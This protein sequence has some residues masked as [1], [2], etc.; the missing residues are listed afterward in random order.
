MKLLNSVYDTD[1]SIYESFSTAIKNDKYTSWSWAVSSFDD[2]WLINECFLPNP[3]KFKHLYLA[4]SWNN[5]PIKNIQSIKDQLKDYPSVKFIDAKRVF[6]PKVY[7]FYN[8]DHTLWEAFVGSFNLIFV[9]G[10]EYATIESV[11]ILTQEDDV[12]GSLFASI[13]R[14]FTET[15]PYSKAIRGNTK[16]Y[17]AHEREK[18]LSHKRK[19]EEKVVTTISILLD[20]LKPFVIDKQTMRGFMFY[21]RF[22]CGESLSD[23]GESVGLTRERIRQIC[24][25]KQAVR[26]AI[27]KASQSEDEAAKIR[28]ILKSTI[29]DDLY[30]DYGELF[31]GKK[32]AEKRA[33]FFKLFKRYYPEIFDSN[34]D[35][36]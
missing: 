36:S 28:E 30:K 27:K 21:Y 31:K 8:E 3:N 6:H 10:D 5:K 32:I 35:N 1:T 11:A 34:R 22:I 7:L 33:D 4:S 2:D 18:A 12:D 26:T 25:K 16:E 29:E 9:D 15:I 17:N 14:M 19:C 20:I 13:M 24:R 23:I